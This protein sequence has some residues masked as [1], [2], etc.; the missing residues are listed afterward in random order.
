MVL[1]SS[2]ES[3]K[4]AGSS[5]IVYEC[6]YCFHTVAFICYTIVISSDE[7]EDSGNYDLQI[8]VE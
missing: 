3:V 1:W 4:V 5:A 8:N 7:E 2:V 6:L